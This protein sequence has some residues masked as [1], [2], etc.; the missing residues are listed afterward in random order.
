M[1]Q[2]AAGEVGEPVD[3]GLVLEQEAAVA[4]SGHARQEG[5]NVA[6]CL[7]HRPS[8]EATVHH[9]EPRAT[10]RGSGYRNPWTVRRRRG[11]P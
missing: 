7:E 5:A 3:L 10:S 9:V 1:V 8:G 6:A 2:G 11:L 4:G